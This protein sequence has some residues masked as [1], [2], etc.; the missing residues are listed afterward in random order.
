MIKYLLLSSFLIVCPSSVFAQ[1]DS[2]MKSKKDSSS[3]HGAPE[4]FRNN[5]SLRIA[6]KMAAKMMGHMMDSMFGHHSPEDAFDSN[7]NFK[8]EFMVKRFPCVALS[9]DYVEDY[10]KGFYAVKDT[11]YLLDSLDKIDTTAPEY[12][13]APVHLFGLPTVLSIVYDSGFV[14]E[15]QWS[16]YGDTNMNRVMD[17]GISKA[18][19]SDFEFIRNT[20]DSNTSLVMTKV[21]D[22]EYYWEADD[23]NNITL[24]LLWK[25]DGK[26]LLSVL[27][28]DSI[29][30]KQA[31]YVL[32]PYFSVFV[33]RWMEIEYHKSPMWENRRKDGYKKLI[34]KCF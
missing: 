20:L 16:F 13:F 9:P 25:K 17:G 24:T 8:T 2:G 4:W 10:L 6:A 30:E 23:E 1:A 27:P 28:T 21:N 7:G 19:R 5:D 34:H 11:I 31:G 22:S 29:P 14:F 26:I 12:R 3:R 33:P 18:T 32:L 15:W